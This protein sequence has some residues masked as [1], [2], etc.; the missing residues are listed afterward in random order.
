MNP[1]GFGGTLAEYTMRNWMVFMGEFKALVEHLN[2]IASE[3]D[4]NG[5]TADFIAT[6]GDYDVAGGEVAVWGGYDTN[7]VRRLGALA[8]AFD[9]WLNGNTVT[10]LANGS[11]ETKTRR[12]MI[13]RFYGPVQ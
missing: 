3:T 9:S 6:E 4:V 2:K 12:D 10:T 13:A 5:V 1:F 7:D 11:T 8:T